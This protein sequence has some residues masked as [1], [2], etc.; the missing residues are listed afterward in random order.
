MDLE[1]YDLEQKSDKRG[2][3]EKDSYSPALL[4]LPLTSVT[5]TVRRKIWYSGYPQTQTHFS[6]QFTQKCKPSRIHIFKIKFDFTYSYSLESLQ[7]RKEISLTH[8]QFPSVFS[9]YIIKVKISYHLLRMY[10]ITY[11]VFCE[12]HVF[13]HINFVTLEADSETWSTLL[14]YTASKW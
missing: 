5:F 13:S 3:P 9:E 11:I 2:P 6:A 4:P 10:Y 12:S 8:E 1:F 7:G 14:S